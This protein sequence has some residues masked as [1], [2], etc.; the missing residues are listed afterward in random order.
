MAGYYLTTFLVLLFL[1]SH[2]SSFPTYDGRVEGNFTST[3]PMLPPLS[4]GDGGSDISPVSVLM[5]TLYVSISDEPPVAPLTNYTYGALLGAVS[6]KFVFDTIALCNEAQEIWV[7]LFRSFCDNTV[8]GLKWAIEKLILSLVSIWSWLVYQAILCI[9]SCAVNY[10]PVLITL[11]LCGVCTRYLFLAVIWMY[12]I[13][14]TCL[15]SFLRI[16]SKV[17]RFRRPSGFKNEKSVEGFTEITFEQSPPGKSVLLLEERRNGEKRH[18]GYA[19]AGKL[20]NG[21]VGLF[22]VAHNLESCDNL[23]VLSERTK[24]SLKLKQFQPIV[25]SKSA[26]LAILRGPVNWEALL[27][28]KGGIYTTSNRLAVSGCTWF[29]YTESWRSHS[30]KVVGTDG[31]LVRV[32]SNTRPGHSGT[33]YFNGKSCL[34]LH[35]GYRLAGDNNNC[36][37]PI[38]PI[39]G[40]TTPD[41]KFETSAPQGLLF[42]SKTI[43]RLEKQ[44]MEMV[45]H[46]GGVWDFDD[47]FA[48]V[49]SDYVGE[50]T[51]PKPDVDE[52]NKIPKDHQSFLRDYGTVLTKHF[53][54]YQSPDSAV[55]L[56]L[57]FPGVKPEQAQQK[58][59]SGNR[60]SR[61]GGKNTGI[62]RTIHPFERKRRYEANRAHGCAYW[63]DQLR[64]NRRTGSR[65]NSEFVDETTQDTRSSWRK[66]EARNIREHFASRY[67]WNIPSPTPEVEG[68]QACGTFAYRY[69][70]KQ[71]QESDWGRFL[72]GQYPALGEETR[73]FGWPEKGAAAELKSLKL[74]ASRW[75]ERANRAEIPTGSA[76]QNVIEQTVRAYSAVANTDTPLCVRS[77]QLVWSDFIEDFKQAVSTL[78]LDAG[79]GIP[80]V[81]FGKPTHR[82]WIE[83]SYLAPI[84][85]QLTFDRLQKMSEVNLAELT[86]AESLVQLGLCDPI[87]TFVKGEPHKQ[88]KLDEGRY[89]LIMSVSLVDQMVARVLFQQQN[90]REIALWRAIPSKPG[91]GVSSDEQV[92]EFISLL[93]QSVGKTPIETVGE[94]KK[95]IIPTDC[96]G[97]DW[98]VAEWML[99]DDMEVRN[100]LTA[101]NNGLLRK[102]RAVWLQCIKQ[103]VLCLSD[104]SLLAQRIPGIQK[105]GSY[106]TSSSNS[107]IRVMCALHCG[108]PWAIAMGDDALE[109]VGSDLALYHKLG[110]K[111]EVSPKLEFCSHLFESET[112]A[113]PV[114]INKMLWK[115]I[116]GYNPASGNLEVISNYLAACASVMH[117]MRHLPDKVDIIKRWLVAPIQPQN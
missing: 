59:S 4:N 2:S 112:L 58:K 3:F 22:T 107:R 117:E 111:V 15:L 81:E 101:N 54:Q 29:D 12:G 9:L 36:M 103:S 62:R 73:G 93:A 60:V 70:C 27:G 23:W 45:R 50:T 38:P 71:L 18:V 7:T 76:R 40:Y 100:R 98:S 82:G 56:N 104:G 46:S 106:N 32:L 13:Q 64:E 88:A 74:Q 14:V 96:S 42:D 92:A 48:V 94:W 97:F 99:D 75:R 77:G 6:S 109:G 31:D 95:Y 105:S 24:N 35:K 10:A 65:Q 80:Y 19:F 20:Y 33:P 16:I 113:L 87:R 102:L 44:A 66:E 52:S 85:A 78:E 49:S 79:V 55:D 41:Y 43:A 90:K 39:P 17:L 69:H 68:F 21:E 11:V 26:D 1:F 30:A 25:L 86:S 8:N 53:G 34:G 110:L 114:N 116:Y 5:E 57:L 108:A 47:A 91:F 83:D 67:Q 89:R 61:A 63:A 115:L 51:L 37:V 72:T 84:L 28:C